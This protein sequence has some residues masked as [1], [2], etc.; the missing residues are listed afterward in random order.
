MAQRGSAA[1]IRRR[2]AGAARRSGGPAAAWG[3]EATPEASRVNAVG[4]V[5]PDGDGRMPGWGI[6]KL[7][8]EAGWG[9]GGGSGTDVCGVF[10]AT[11]RAEDRHTT[12]PRTSVSVDGSVG[13]LVVALGCV[14][15]GDGIY[16]IVTC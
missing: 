10:G 15:S 8:R 3:F 13:L 2:G 6:Q 14:W 4:E 11:Q 7:K 5:W 16:F 12:P 1:S 9:A